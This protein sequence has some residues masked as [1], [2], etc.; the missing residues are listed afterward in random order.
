[1]LCRDELV[2]QHRGDAFFFLT[3]CERGPNVEPGGLGWNTVE[4][5]G[6][7]RKGKAHSQ[8]LLPSSSTAFFPQVVSGMGN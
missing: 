1:M 6:K 8:N 4:E 2:E 7:E 3:L 5:G